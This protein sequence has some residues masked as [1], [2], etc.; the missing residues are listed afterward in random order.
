MLLQRPI[1]TR[2]RFGSVAERLSLATLKQLVGS[3]CKRHAVTAR[4]QLPPLVGE[5][6]Q[7]LFHS[8]VRGAS[9]LSLTVLVHYRSSAV[10]S[11]AGWSPQIRTGF[12]VPRPTQVSP[13]SITRY[14]YGSFTLC[15]AVFQTAS[16]SC[17]RYLLV[18]LQPRNVRKHSGLGSSLFARHYWG[19]RLFLSFPPGTKMFQFPGF[20]PSVDGTGSSIQWVAP[21]GYG[22]INSC[23]PIPGLFRSLPRPS[24]PAE[25]KASSIRPC[26][27]FLVNQLSCEIVST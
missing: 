4:M 15:A 10:F 5:R 21:F 7:V 12:H 9:H 17:Y 13:Y 18:I 16:G 24:S 26:F 3:L 2:S 19:N 1:Q 23:L 27:S 8:P 6:F 22:R 11:L 20:A 14:P 25:A